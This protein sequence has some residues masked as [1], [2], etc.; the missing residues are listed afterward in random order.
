MLDRPATWKKL[1]AISQSS[2]HPGSMAIRYERSYHLQDEDETEVEPHETIK[3]NS[4][5]A[6]DLYSVIDLHVYQFFI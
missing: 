6:T 4:P 1:S 5:L 2:A 3:G